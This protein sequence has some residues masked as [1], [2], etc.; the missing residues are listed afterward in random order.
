MK[1]YTFTI[2]GSNLTTIVYAF[3]DRFSPEFEYMCKSGNARIF[4]LE[5]FKLR[6]GC[7]LAVIVILDFKNEDKCVVTIISAGGRAGI[8][9]LDIF[10]AEESSLNNVR[11][12]FQALAEERKWKIINL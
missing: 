11:T 1:E 3:R 2:K 7:D 4:V 8:L 10:G 12:F 6:Q 5:E 9:R